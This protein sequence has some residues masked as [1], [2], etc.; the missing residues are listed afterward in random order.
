MPPTY[1]T[2]TAASQG[3]LELGDDIA[4]EG[5]RQKVDTD[6]LDGALVGF[7]E[8]DILLRYPAE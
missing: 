4:G 5:D 7:V 8:D 1:L 3:A 6:A 2:A